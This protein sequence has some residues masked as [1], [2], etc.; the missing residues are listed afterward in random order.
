[1]RFLLLFLLLSQPVWAWWDTGHKAV[2]Q[3]A[4]QNMKPSTRARVTE[5][6][7]HHPDPNVRTL[8]EAAVWPDLIRDRK[9]PFHSFHRGSWHYENRPVGSNPQSMP[10][11]GDLLIELPHQ[12]EKLTDSSISLR[13]RALALS[14]VVHLVGDI[15]QPL[16]SAALYDEN[17][18]QGDVAGNLY[19]VDLGN[20]HLNLHNVWD[21]AG[22]RFLSPISTQRLKSFVHYAQEQHP[23][24][25][26]P[27]D[28]RILDPDAW[29]DEGV[30]LCRSTVYTGI[31]P[32]GELSSEYLRKTLDTTEKQIALSGYRL[33]WLLDIVLANAAPY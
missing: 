20:Q 9:H 17:F 25:S 19:C 13:Q 2:A 28:A 4:L 10:T 18:P 27:V 8:E 22:C 7:R 16:H 29:S 14:W 24:S 1:M 31:E 3:I 26:F 12:S 23:V 33:A 30:E 5:L 21:S 11:Q 15:H 32:D 6:L